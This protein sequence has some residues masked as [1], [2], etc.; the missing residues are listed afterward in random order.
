MAQDDF[1]G[2]GLSSRASSTINDPDRV[3]CVF[4]A[5]T[6]I[7]WPWHCSICY[8]QEPQSFVVLNV[9]GATAPGFQ[10]LLNP[11]LAV[12]AVAAQQGS[13]APEYYFVP[14]CPACRP[15][16]LTE[17]IVV[18]D[19]PSETLLGEMSAGNGCVAIAFANA[20][21]AR[22][23]LELNRH[24]AFPNGEGIA[25]FKP[26]ESLQASRE[27]RAKRH[28]AAGWKI[29]EARLAEIL[30]EFESVK[31]FFT[32]P[33]IPSAKLAT[34]SAKCEVPAGETIV[35]LLDLTTFGSGKRAIVFGL[36]GVYAKGMGAAQRLPY[37]EFPS[38][39]FTQAKGSPAIAAGDGRVFPA[40]GIGK[41][42]PLLK[43]LGQIK[44]EVMQSNQRTED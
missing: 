20:A 18:P 33:N 2:L 27:E 42:Y 19:N 4:P 28:K 11:L 39:V 7:D 22:E 21:Y 43:I 13:P 15:F 44:N 17:P 26:K 41:Q 5:L 24:L 1:V 32:K 6:D 35:G 12:A 3:T 10:V 37:N 36:E 40:S 34:A 31:S 23:F 38:C 16:G 8:D 25:D 30:K 14:V 9:V 29:D